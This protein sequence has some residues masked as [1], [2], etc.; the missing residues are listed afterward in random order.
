MFS[1]VKRKFQA[2]WEEM[3]WGLK[4]SFHPRKHP[5]NDTLLYNVWKFTTVQRYLKFSFQVGHYL[6]K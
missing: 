1:R 4:F 2:P 3:P 6:A 5:L